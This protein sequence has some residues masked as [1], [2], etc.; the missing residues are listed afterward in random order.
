[1]KS[2]SRLERLRINTLNSDLPASSALD[3]QFCLPSSPYSSLHPPT[4]SLTGVLSLS[5]RLRN[6]LASLFLAFVY[7]LCLIVGVGG[8]LFTFFTIGPSL[9]T[10]YFPAVSKLQILSIEPVGDH[11]TL[12]RAAFEKRRD[13]EY[14]GITWFVGDRASEFERVSVLLK[15]ADGDTSSPNRPLG[16]QRAGPWVIGL[17]PGDLIN[18]SFAQLHHRCHPFWTTATDFFP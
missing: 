13:C 1:M 17:P 10:R 12:I 6:K 3:G 14:I 8:M 18:R 16:Y 9:E 7:A 11:S 4:S 15:R 2:L 5:K